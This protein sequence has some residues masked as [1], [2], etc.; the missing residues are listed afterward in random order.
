MFESKIRF[1]LFFPNKNNMKDKENINK[2]QKILSESTKYF[3]FLI[4]FQKL[5]F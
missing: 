1:S 2:T 5:V 3:R 4:L